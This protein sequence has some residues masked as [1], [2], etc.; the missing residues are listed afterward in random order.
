[1]S[2]ILH[3]QTTIDCPPW[4]THA[5][6]ELPENHCGTLVKVNNVSVDV[7]QFIEN[8]GTSP[9][10]I[11]ARLHPSDVEFDAQQCR[12]LAAA[13]MEA[14]RVI[15]NAAEQV[16]ALGSIDPTLAPM[17]DDEAVREVGWIARESLAMALDDIGLDSPRGQTYLARKRALLAHIEA[18]R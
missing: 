14:A 5:P 17:T 2:T 9:G 16:E 11:M 15:D 12:D 4:C 7:D 10:A 3:D 18:R 1:M 6:H 8:D 13:L